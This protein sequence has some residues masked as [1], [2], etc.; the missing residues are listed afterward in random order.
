MMLDTKKH[1]L[2]HEMMVV[3]FDSPLGKKYM[4][5]MPGEVADQV[6]VQLGD[7]EVSR[8]GTWTL[9]CLRPDSR[10]EERLF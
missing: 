5:E 3:Q 9:D 2:S 7:L 4:G 1:N 8:V 6:S 10:Q